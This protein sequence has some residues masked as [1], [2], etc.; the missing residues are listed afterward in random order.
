MLIDSWSSF[1]AVGS[2]VVCIDGWWLIGRGG[3]SYC[4]GFVLVVGVTIHFNV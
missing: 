2:I 3:M 4:F 1:I